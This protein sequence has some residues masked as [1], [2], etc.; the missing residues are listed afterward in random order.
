MSLE[1]LCDSSEAQLQIAGKKYPKA[2]LYTDFDQ[3][4]KSEKPDLLTIATRTP[5]RAR[6]IGKA[7]RAG[8]T[9]L[10]VEKP[11][12]NS[13]PELKILAKLFQKKNLHVTYGTLRRYQKIYQHAVEMAHSGKYGKLLEVSAEFG[14]GT[15]AWCHP[16]S[17]DCILFAARRRKLIDVQAHLGKLMFGENRNQIKNDPLVLS[18]NMYFKDGLCGTISMKHGMDFVLS[19][20]KAQII[21]RADGRSLG[22]KK[23]NSG[24][25]FGPEKKLFFEKALYSGTAAPLNFLK[26]C[27]EKKRW[28]KR[29]SKTLKTDII[30]TQKIIFSFIDS[31]RK[32]TIKNSSLGSNPNTFLLAK[33]GSFIA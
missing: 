25:Y 21:V 14:A 20:E 7:V 23:I 11:L 27:L 8:V 1:A 31:T 19:C 16:H 12:C 22:I 3:L 5:G 28:A 4:L 15:L 10:H 32:Q 18:G 24:G 13:M 29:E 2:R 9:A 26:M 6:L 30:N 17:I 33:T